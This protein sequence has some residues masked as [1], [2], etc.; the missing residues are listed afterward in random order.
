MRL[1]LTDFVWGVLDLVPRTNFVGH[2]LQTT[3]LSNWSY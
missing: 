1:R 2:I 3:E